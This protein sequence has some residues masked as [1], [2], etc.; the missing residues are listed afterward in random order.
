MLIN[1]ATRPAVT[2]PTTRTPGVRAS[3]EL[4]LTYQFEPGTDAD[5]VTVAHPAAVLNQVAADGFDWQI[6][7]LRAGAGHRADPV[8][9]QGVRRNFVPA[10]DYAADFLDRRRARPEEPLLDGAGARAAPD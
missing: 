10:P 5:G 4:P 6:P 1:A 8:A 9:A 3:C 2:R 7:G